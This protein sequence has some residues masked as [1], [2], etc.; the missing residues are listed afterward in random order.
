MHRFK[1]RAWH[2]GH[3]RMIDVYGLGPDFLTENTFDG[4]D[5]GTNA[6][7]GEDMSF[8]KVMQ[9]SGLKDKNGTEIF[10]GDIVKVDFN[11]GGSHDSIQFIEFYEG[12]FG[13]R[14]ENDHFRIPALYSGRAIEGMNTNYYEVIGNIHQNPDLL[15]GVGDG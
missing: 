12:S 1:F 6:F 7:D 10:E 13:S 2:T 8:L 4:V 3:K 5:P 14:R 9:Y 15:K 11:R